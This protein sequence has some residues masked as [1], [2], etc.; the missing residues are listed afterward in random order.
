MAETLKHSPIWRFKRL[1]ALEKEDIS[2]VYIYAFFNGIVNLSLPLGVQAIVNLIQGGQIT[3][4]WYVLV[5]LVIV[6][7]AL[8]GF[9]QLLQLRIVENISQKIFSN[10]SF[11][12]ALRIPKIKYQA[13]RDYYGPDLANRFFD[14]LTIQKG[15]PKILIDFS[16]GIF[17]VIVGLV[18]LSLYHPF[19]IIFSVLLLIVVYLIIASTGPRGLRTSIEESSSKYKIAFWLEEIARSKLSFKLASDNKLSLIKTDEN[20]NNYLRSREKHFGIIIS[21][22]VYLIIFKV[23]V[24]AGLLITGS[25]LVFNEQM[26]IGQFVA[27]EIII[28]LIIASVE[29]IIKTIESIYDVLTALEKI[30]FVFDKP[31]DEYDGVTLKDSD[32]SFSIAVENLSFR[33][34]SAAATSLQNLSFEIPVN[35]SAFISG[36]PSSG[37]STLMKILSGILEPTDGIIKYNGFPLRSLDFDKL[38]EEIGFCISQGEI[39][40]GTILDNISLRRDNATPENINRALKITGL[41]PYLSKMPLGFNTIIDP[42]GK[43]VP[44]NIQKRI[45]LARAIAT[46]PRLLILEDPLDHVGNDEKK[47]LIS[48]LTDIKNRWRVI[49]SS[50]DDI[51]KEHIDTVI[52]IN[53]GKIVSL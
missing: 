25:I 22:S 30:G 26:N 4:S 52:E 18:V 33:Y 6:G 34:E 36:P 19:F 45:L 38:K 49:I 40:Q 11:E 1:L 46:N 37:K 41:S 39:F 20:V 7:V 16:L 24:A 53:D 8:T 28:I 15:L 47:E 23:L 2:Q 43:K 9:L 5:C 14:T 42:E 31:M 35:K 51:W 3:T 12:F 21:Q 29:K 44:T 13:F 27:A 10:A 48:A 32:D 17:Q 50:V